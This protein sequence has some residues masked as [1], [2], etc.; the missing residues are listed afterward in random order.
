MSCHFD[1]SF[2]LLD[3]NSS[4]LTFKSQVNFGEARKNL[5]LR[6]EISAGV[7]FGGSALFKFDLAFI[8]LKFSPKFLPLKGR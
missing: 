4:G 8:C 3:L 1:C 2:L 7:K 5:S 6:L